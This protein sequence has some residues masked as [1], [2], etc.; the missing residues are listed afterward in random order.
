MFASILLEMKLYDVSVPIQ[1]GMPVW[2][3]DPGLLVRL[4][5][6]IAKGA[7]ANV[8]RIDMGAHTGTHMDA[9]FHFEPNGYG[10]DQIP[11]EVLIGPCR[12]FDLTNIEGHINRAAL[13]KCDLRGVMRALFKTGN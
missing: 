6:S 9:P 1:E 10:I 12:V 11:L 2:P 4:A 3:S 5:S 8:T 7:G 13:V